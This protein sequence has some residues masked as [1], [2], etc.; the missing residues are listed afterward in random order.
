M[1]VE[2][3]KVVPVPG[4]GANGN[5]IG[6]LLVDAGKIIPQDAERVLRYAKEK[7]VR[8][9]DAAIAL[10]LVSRE[11]VDRMIATQFGYSYVMPGE[12]PVSHEVVAAYLPFSRQV[13]ALRA[14]RSQLLLRWFGESL[15]RRR[16]AI[17]SLDHGDG[18]SYLAANLAVVFSQLGERTLLVDA[19]MR[20]PR[21]HSI[22]G[23]NNAVGLS[24]VLSERAGTEAIQRIPAFQDLSLLPAGPLPP[25][26]QELL[27][28]S[29]FV[30][31]MD[32]WSRYFDVVL[33]DTAA[34]SQV[35]DARI[36][37]SKAEGAFVLTRMNK[38]RLREV[39]S[40]YEDLS[41]VG[42]TLVGTVI[43]R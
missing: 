7:G 9:G 17:V 28:R 32:D 29:T 20:S 38:T 30:E 21:Q 27:E 23:F 5:Q 2:R 35:A 34:A 6:A 25:N 8:F 39:K 13:E 36:V 26:P 31:A 22:F 18:R 43:N 4:K 19:D 3:T 41:Q 33:L 12:S 14:L 10:G 42:V 15:N 11:E 40:L 24:T 1:Q 37:A 16:M